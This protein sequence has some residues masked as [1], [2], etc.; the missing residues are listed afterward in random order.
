ML[1]R[2]LQGTTRATLGSYVL[3]AV[4][5]L[6]FLVQ[7]LVLGWWFAAI[8]V[9]P[10]VGS[11]IINTRKIHVAARAGAPSNLS[12]RSAPQA[13]ASRPAGGAVARSHATSAGRLAAAMEED[14]ERSARLFEMT[15]GMGSKSA[16]QSGQTVLGVARDSLAV[17]LKSS[18]LTFVP[19]NPSIASTQIQELEPRCIVVDLGAFAVGPWGGTLDAGGT[20]LMREL[21]QALDVAKREDVDVVVVSSDE[22]NDHVGSES[23]RQRASRVI[24]DAT[25]ESALAASVQAVANAN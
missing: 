13:G 19:L 10:L 16:A 4:A 2:L 5:G 18:D 12:F 22:T 20:P 21:L 11:G 8:A 1:R 17:A 6:L 25:D 9:I 3:I 7:F 15:G 24:H 23:L 14:P